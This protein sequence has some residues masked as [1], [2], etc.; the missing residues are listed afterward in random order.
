MKYRISVAR[1]FVIDIDSEALKKLENIYRNHEVVADDVKLIEQACVDVETATG[2][3][4]G[5]PGYMGDDDTI[6]AVAVA[7][8]NYPIIEW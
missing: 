2:I 7:E 5:E 1:E 3:P 4:V 6:Y 8:D